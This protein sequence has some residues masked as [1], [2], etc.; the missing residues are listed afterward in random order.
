M[1]IATPM[2]AQYILHFILDHF[3][4]LRTLYVKLLGSFLP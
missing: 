2:K 1:V 4:H 3:G